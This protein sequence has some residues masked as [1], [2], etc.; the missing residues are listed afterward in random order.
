MVESP[1]MW[2]MDE[3]VTRRLRRSSMGRSEVTAR[4]PTIIICTSVGSTVSDTI[5]TWTELI[6]E[7][8]GEAADGGQ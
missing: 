5:A 4:W 7:E 8:V 1:Q 3:Q 2:C 6:E